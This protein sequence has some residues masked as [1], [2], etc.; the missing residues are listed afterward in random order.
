VTALLW[1]LGGS[2]AA[3]LAWLAAAVAIGRKGAGRDA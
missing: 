1:V 3:G 2:Y